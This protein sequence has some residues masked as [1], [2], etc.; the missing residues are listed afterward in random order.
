MIYTFLPN[1]AKLLKHGDCNNKNVVYTKFWREKR[2]NRKQLI[3]Q[4]CKKKSFLTVGL[5]TEFAKIPKVFMG[6]KDPQLACNKA[7]IE[8]TSPYAVAYKPNLA[9]YESLGYKGII[10]L[11]KTLDYIPEDAFKIADAKRGDIGN[12]S[13]LYAK[14]FFETYNFDAITVSP[15]MGIDSISPFLEYE[16]K[17][18]IIIALTSNEG[19]KDFQLLKNDDGMLF[20][21]VL[22]KSQAWGTPN[23]IMYVVGA[24]HPDSLVKIRTIIPEHFILLPG[25]G[26]QGGDLEKSSKNAVNKNDVS[27]LAN[28]SRAI[29]FPKEPEGGFQSIDDYKF[30][31]AK[32]AEYYQN[33]MGIFLLK[34]GII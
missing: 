15:Y 33:E 28:V 4:I 27:I 30:A 8:A 6:E 25:I 2:M 1:G 21:A 26:A 13:R 29:I 9:F 34:E 31:V 12:T 18:V 23:N 16:D 24:T 7:I 3:Y 14:T 17:W 19:S 11:E 22:H 32:Q 20:E 10:T 5:D